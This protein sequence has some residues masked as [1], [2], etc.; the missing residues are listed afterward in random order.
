MAK[1]FIL[2]PFLRDAAIYFYESWDHFKAAFLARFGCSEG[3]RCRDTSDMYTTS[4][5]IDESAEDFVA[6][7]TKKA[8]YIP[9]I[10]EAFLRSAVIQ[11]R[12]PQIRSHV[13]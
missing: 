2:S 10:D 12:R 5:K 9:N 4:Q 6:R 3:V 11:G 7:V 13:L 8:K 1:N